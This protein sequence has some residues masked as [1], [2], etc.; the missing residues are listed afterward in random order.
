LL[1]E[2]EKP[3]FI[4]LASRRYSL[5]AIIPASYG[6]A[7]GSGRGVSYGSRFCTSHRKGPNPKA[8]KTDYET[9]GSSIWRIESTILLP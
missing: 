6:C 8:G 9:I 5:L 4:G 7:K 1:L 2:N 3:S